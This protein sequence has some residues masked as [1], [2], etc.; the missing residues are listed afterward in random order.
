MN[1]LVRT[2]LSVVGLLAFGLFAYIF[3]LDQIGPA[4]VGPK[5]EVGAI[6]Q[7]IERGMTTA[8]IGA[9][10]R[11]S[12]EMLNSSDAAGPDMTPLN[13]NRLQVD[14]QHKN[15]FVCIC[16]VDMADGIAT[17]SGDLFCSD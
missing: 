13:A 12:L 11:A 9:S 7:A 16:Q 8:E 14:I 15:G 1:K 2:S 3:Y 4:W 5:P 10:R 6:C 17:S